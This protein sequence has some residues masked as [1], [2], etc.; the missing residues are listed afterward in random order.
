[1]P[2][3]ESSLTELAKFS[4]DFSSEISQGLIGLIGL[5]GSAIFFE[6]EHPVRGI[7]DVKS[8]KENNFIN[9]I[10]VLDEFLILILNYY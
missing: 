7:N 2:L 5:I 10:E 1:M 8:I 3:N 9:T 6:L 4:W